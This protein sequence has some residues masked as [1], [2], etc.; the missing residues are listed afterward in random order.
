MTVW[1]TAVHP[2]GMDA[3]GMRRIV[4]ELL[5]AEERETWGHPT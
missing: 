4:G 3:A 5:E 2:T 1:R